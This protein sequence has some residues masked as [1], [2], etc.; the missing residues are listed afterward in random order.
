MVLNCLLSVVWAGDIILLVEFFMD[1]YKPGVVAHIVIPT[2]RKW[3]QK[4]Q[5]FKVIFRI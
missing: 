4:D 3:K 1:T 2:L 5:K